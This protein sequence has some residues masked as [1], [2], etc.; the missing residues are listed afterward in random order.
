MDPVVID[1]GPTDGGTSEVPPGAESFGGPVVDVHFD[2]IVVDPV[3]FIEPIPTDAGATD[4]APTDETPADAGS[5]DAGSTDAGSTDGGSTDLPPGAETFGGP[6]A[7]IQYDHVVVDPVVFIDSLPADPGATDVSPT[8]AA[9]TDGTPTDGSIADAGSTD[10]GSTDSGS[11]DLPPGA[12]TFGGPDADIQFHH[13]VVGPV[14]IDPVFDSAPSDGTTADPTGTDS[15]T[16]IEG[17]PTDNS[18]D[19]SGNGSTDGTTGSDGTAD[20]GF[21]YEDFI[22]IYGKDPAILYYDG[23][24]PLV[25][26]MSGG[27]PIAPD[28]SATPGRSG[29][30]DPLPYERT[31][32]AVRETTTLQ[33]HDAPTDLTGVHIAG[34]GVGYHEPLMY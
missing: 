24:P 3:V 21:S 19:E 5:T 14:L 31:T 1:A 33:T 7:G 12:E 30:H 8:D 27:D 32:T 10:A 16:A 11:T 18:G 17:A 29:G 4:A 20:G 9:Q 2:H 34:A 25:Y 28:D 15:G 23:T 26:T 6:D 13:V 22:A